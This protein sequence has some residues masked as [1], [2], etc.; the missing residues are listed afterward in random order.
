[1][2]M[3]KEKETKEKDEDSNPSPA[4]KFFQEEDTK[5]PYNKFYE[6]DNEL[7]LSKLDD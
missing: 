4:L 6:S 1:M 3:T 7:S 5:L 2:G